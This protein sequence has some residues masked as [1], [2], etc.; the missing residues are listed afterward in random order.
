MMLPLAYFTELV[1]SSLTIKPSGMA[2]AVGISASGPSTMT[3]NAQGFL[4][5]LTDLSSNLGDVAKQIEEAATET[6]VG[7][8]PIGEIGQQPDLAEIDAELEEAMRM[9]R[10]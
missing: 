10:Q 6:V 4:S 5:G 3:R 9:E 2:N 7:A 1:I 8:Q